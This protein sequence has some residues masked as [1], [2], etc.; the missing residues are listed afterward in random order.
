MCPIG[1]TKPFFRPRLI[2]DR[3]DTPTRSFDS[4]EK[5]QGFQHI[6]RHFGRAP[7]FLAAKQ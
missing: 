1:Q 5:Q 6:E 2:S 4:N 3:A 7:D